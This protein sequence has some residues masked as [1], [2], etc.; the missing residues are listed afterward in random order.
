M[1][2]RFITETWL[3]Q[4]Y[5]LAQGSE[6]HLRCGVCGGDVAD[7]LILVAGPGENR[8]EERGTSR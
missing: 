4:Q 2:E 7:K 3:R 5:G 8:G 6:V 1:A